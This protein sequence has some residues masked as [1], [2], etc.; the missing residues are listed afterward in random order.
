MRIAIN[1]CHDYK[2]S[3][4]FQKVDLHKALEELPD[5]Y[6]MTE[7]A[8]ALLTIDVM[9]LPEKLKQVVLLHYYQEL[10]IRECA[11]VLHIAPSTVH[12]RLKQAE[13]RLKIEFAGGEKYGK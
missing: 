8:D 4:W 3:K 5:R 2:R 13:Q 6:L 10:T 12:H 9:R 1:V 11:E 7:D